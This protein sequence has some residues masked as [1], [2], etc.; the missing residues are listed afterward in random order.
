[1]R[2]PLAASL[3]ARRGFTHVRPVLGEGMGAWHAPELSPDPAP[4]P[5]VVASE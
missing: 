5:A 1:V 3:L 2:S 4:Q